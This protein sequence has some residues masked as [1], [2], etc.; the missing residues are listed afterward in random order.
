[1][2]PNAEDDLWANPS[3]QL[4]MLKA[5]TPVYQLLGGEGL[6]A[7]AKP[8][9]NKLIDGR[10]GYFIRPGKHAMTRADWEIFIQ[11]CDKWLGNK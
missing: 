10:L 8:E 11:Y 5:A 1:L 3:G 6:A 2:L 4:E 7:E 9:M